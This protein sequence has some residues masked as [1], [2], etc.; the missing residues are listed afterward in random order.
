M[1]LIIS[2]IMI[3]SPNE[4]YLK[5]VPIYEPCETWFNKHVYHDSKRNNHYIG[6]EITMGYICNLG[7]S[8]K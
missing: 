5:H 8:G 7:K 1:E 6:N 2:L 3:I 4:Y